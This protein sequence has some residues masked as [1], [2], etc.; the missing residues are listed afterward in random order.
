MCTGLGDNTELFW[1]VL[2]HRHPDPSASSPPYRAR[3]SRPPSPSRGARHRDPSASSPPN[4]PVVSGRGG[5]PG[6][7]R[8]RAEP[9]A[10]T[11]APRPHPI[12]LAWAAEAEL[13][14]IEAAYASASAKRRRLPDWTSPSP[15]S[16][17]RYSQRSPA[18]G[19]STPSWAFTPPP[20]KVRYLSS[21]LPF[22]VLCFDY[23]SRKREGKV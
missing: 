10:A 21:L 16:R 3:S 11:P 5:A 8:P 23:A 18:S 12:A 7:R 15:S 9:D 19:G 13:Q 1:A 4:R 14:A 20:C 17:P 6:H 2:S 22:P